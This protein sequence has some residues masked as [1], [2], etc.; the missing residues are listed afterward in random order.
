MSSDALGKLRIGSAFCTATVI[1]PLDEGD[2][3]V[4]ILTAAH[5]IKL[6]EAG[7]F[8]MSDGR[9]LH[10]KCI[11]RDAASDC[12]WLRAVHP[13]GDVAY[14]LL[15][16]ELPDVGE[17][18]FHQG[19]GIDKPE[20]KE[21]GLFKGVTGNGKQCNFRLSVSPGDSGGAIIL[22]HNGRVVSPVCCTTRIAG[23]G[24][25][26]G[27]TPK[28]CAA[29]RPQNRTSEDEPPLLNPIHLEAAGFR[30]PFAPAN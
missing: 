8:T 7:L 22:D 4:D 16:D 15:A 19:F 6:N 13:G 18:V 2:S 3:H 5:C 28:A 30:T 17:A 14:L 26:Y 20:N 27:A 24:D 11:A 23:V 9:V 21:V 25:V 1:G 10:A 12:A 29:C